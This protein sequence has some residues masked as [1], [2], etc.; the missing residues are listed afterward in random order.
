MPTPRRSAS[1]QKQKPGR[2]LL[3]SSNEHR[4]M[5]QRYAE[6]PALVC[7]PVITLQTFSTRM[8][9]VLELFLRVG[10]ILRQSNVQAI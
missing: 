2:C 3:R 7:A 8:D 4:R 1:L 5:R 10:S 9:T 6:S